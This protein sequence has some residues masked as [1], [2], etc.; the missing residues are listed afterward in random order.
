M[1]DIRMPLAAN[2]G[3]AVRAALMFHGSRLQDYSLAAALP[4]PVENR[5][6]SRQDHQRAPD[7]ASRRP[8]T[9]IKR[10]AKSTCP[11]TRLGP[12]LLQFC[13]ILLVNGG[14]ASGAVWP[15]G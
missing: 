14:K 10:V 1:T 3:S 12:F 5:T 2:S 6:L 11:G 7:R 8:M 4:R 15:G 9:V 13:V